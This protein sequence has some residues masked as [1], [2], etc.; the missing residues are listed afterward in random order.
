MHSDISALIFDL[1]GTLYINNSLGMEISVAACRY[2]ADLKNIS[3]DEAGKLID[4][5][6]QDLSQATGLDSTL[7]H[8]I[9][10]LGGDLRTLHNRFAEEIDP[11]KLLTC[12]RRVVEMLRNLGNKFEMYIY[13]N[14]NVKLSTRIM[15]LIGIDGLFTEVFTI[16]EDW[17]PKP[18]REAVAKLFKIIRRDPTEC[19][20]VGDRYDVDL[21]I[22][23]EMG[24]AVFLV[25]SVIEL[26][27]LAKFLS[28]EN[29]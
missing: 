29:L 2:V 28:K 22:P 7:S 25:S 3:V 8:T 6:R 17:R 24:S 26:L 10:A 15:E 16:E 1:D 11:G 9:L 27:S 5:T 18:D 19:L 23:A 12:D 4:Q 21:R 20:F 14:N 13:T